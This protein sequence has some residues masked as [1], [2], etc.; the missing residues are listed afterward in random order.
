MINREEYMSSLISISEAADEARANGAGH[1]SR[2]SGKN[3][4]AAAAIG[5]G[6]MALAMTGFGTRGNGNSNEAST[7]D[8]TAAAVSLD[9]MPVA[10]NGFDFEAGTSCG[11]NDN[12]A[13]GRQTYEANKEKIQSYYNETR[14]ELFKDRP[15]LA[16]GR[17]HW[18]NEHAPWQRELLGDK[19]IGDN[20]VATM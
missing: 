16:L 18:I 19:W 13:E 11:P 1:E 10:F 14:K 6:A 8:D 15:N 2:R 9:T 7:F 12:R 4:I 20:P 17:M 3:A 5:F